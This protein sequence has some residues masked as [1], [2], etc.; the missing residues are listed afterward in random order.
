MRCEIW[1]AGYGM[2][3]YNLLSNRLF[4]TLSSRSSLSP[5]AKYESSC[6]RVIVLRVAELFGQRR[7]Q[8]ATRRAAAAGKRREAQDSGADKLGGKVS[9][10]SKT[11]LQRR[12]H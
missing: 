7:A 5:S 2:R 9:Q 1:Y 4:L 3:P 10:V 6:P 11:A 8:A 12:V